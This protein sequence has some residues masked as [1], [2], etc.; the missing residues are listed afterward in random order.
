MSDIKIKLEFVNYN[1]S[2]P[3]GLCFNDKNN[4]GVSRESLNSL[5]MNALHNAEELLNDGDSLIITIETEDKEKLERHKKWEEEREEKRVSR[6]VGEKLA[7]LIKEQKGSR[8]T[9]ILPKEYISIP[10]E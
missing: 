4:T 3:D 1:S 2:A 9:N 6:L 5:A 10:E 7:S 8:I